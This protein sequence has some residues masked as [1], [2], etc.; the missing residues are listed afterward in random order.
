MSYSFVKNSANNQIVEETQLI[1]VYELGKVF[2]CLYDKRELSGYREFA[3]TELADFI[4]MSRMLCEQ[5]GWNY[6]N[7]ITSNSNIF[8]NTREQLLAKMQI[9]L[10]KI[11]RGLH[12]KKRFDD[13]RGDSP[14]ICMQCLVDQTRWLCGLLLFDFWEVVELGELRYIERMH[15]LMSNGIK[16]QLKEEF[17]GKE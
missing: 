5:V 10:G 2:E 4:S 13:Y 6:D 14:D 16:S 7:M 1:M 11:I 15:D 8:V 9:L 12:Y 17:R 3:R